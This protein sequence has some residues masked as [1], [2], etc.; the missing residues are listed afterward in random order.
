[1]EME[2]AV[3]KAI[4][5]LYGSSSEPICPSKIIE[6]VCKECGIDDFDF[7][8][9]I[10]EETL[11]ED[12]NYVPVLSEDGEDEDEY[13]EADDAEIFFSRRGLFAKAQFCVCPTA[14]EIERGI[15]IP[16][17]R[18]VPFFDR[19]DKIVL[20]TGEKRGKIKRT[21]RNI[22]FVSLS[23]Y[24]SLFGPRGMMEQVL[25][26]AEDN[27]QAF[28]DEMQSG[29]VDPNSTC[30]VS[31]YDFKAFYAANKIVEGDILLVSIID[32]KKKLCT[33]ERLP[34]DRLWQAAKWNNEFE[35]GLRKNIDMVDIIGYME[36]IEAFLSRAFFYSD[37]S[38]LQAPSSMLVN[39]LNQHDDLYL[40][41]SAEG[42]A[43]IWEKD[44]EFELVEEEEDEDFEFDEDEDEEFAE[45]FRLDELFK[46]MGFSISA[47]ELEAYMRDELFGGG[48]SLE[49]VKK[50]CFDDRVEQHYPEL[51]KEF[52]QEIKELWE[53][54]KSE[55]N[56]FQDN[57]QG[58]IRKKALEFADMHTA[59]IRKLDMNAIDINDSLKKD[60]TKIFE[61]LGPVYGLIALLNDDQVIE[62]K[63]VKGYSGMLDMAMSEY[64]KMIKKLDKK[65]G[66]K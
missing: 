19:E 54:V 30:Q 9:A 64:D 27:M 14:F 7:L 33:I 57:P 42:N 45:E 43:I 51:K 18:F 41:I 6:A 44:R 10:I 36:P 63:Q 56:I 47:N 53:T 49:R 29:E 37:H 32:H 65:L 22:P 2:K 35:I 66:I 4:D 52:N 38:L 34:Q 60:L 15:L 62:P 40:E 31:V 17:H 12:S 55:Y 61:L 5:K 16:G 26:E 28:L 48:D 20:E 58:K 1:M 21:K 11:S 13:E 24:Y 8:S 3:V 23:V 59:W 50:R 39:V 25:I 46:T